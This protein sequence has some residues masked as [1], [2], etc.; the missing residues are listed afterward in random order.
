MSLWQTCLQ[1][2]ARYQILTI[3]VVLRGHS[4]WSECVFIFFSMG[5]D[6]EAWWPKS[7]SET[8]T[9]TSA[10]LSNK[11]RRFN[12]KYRKPIALPVSLTEKR[13]YHPVMR[14]INEDQGSPCAPCLFPSLASVSL[15]MAKALDKH[16]TASN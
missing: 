6:T 8:T 1:F 11:W 16:A 3:I 15:P 9:E 4:D 5:L 7:Q 12:N 13:T 14:K 10:H 2:G